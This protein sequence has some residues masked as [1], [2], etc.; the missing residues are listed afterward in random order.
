[1]PPHIFPPGN[2]KCLLTASAHRIL[3]NVGS[4]LLCA[5]YEQACVAATDVSQEYEAANER[6]FKG[7]AEEA[8]E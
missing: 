6:R 2:L 5:M 7:A 8:T 1:M 4:P 3:G